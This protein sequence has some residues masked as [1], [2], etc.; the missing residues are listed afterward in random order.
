MKQLEV[1]SKFSS[2]VGLKVKLG[3]GSKVKSKIRS[4]I[5][6]KSYQRS[7]LK[8]VKSYVNSSKSKVQNQRSKIRNIW[9]WST[10]RSKSWVRSYK[11]IAIVKD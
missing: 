4:N 7:S 11:Y 9:F 6:W 1:G 2:K 3:V 5:S 8:L 10:L